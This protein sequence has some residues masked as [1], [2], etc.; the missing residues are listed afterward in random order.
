MHELNFSS[1]NRRLMLGGIAPKYVS[2]TIKELR[3]HLEEL[4]QA[5]R[6]EGLSEQEV[7]SQANS[8]LGEED[9]LVTE[10]LAKPELKSW[11]HR[12]TKSIYV[13]IPFVFYICA[14]V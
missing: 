8:K 5:A 12:Y 11:S 9:V 6:N 4:K 14:I 1:L 2:R 7:I 13:F 3:A 10:A